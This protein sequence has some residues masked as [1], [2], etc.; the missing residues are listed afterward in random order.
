MN[1][2]FIQSHGNEFLDL[3]LEDAQ[4]SVSGQPASHPSSLAKPLS[5]SLAGLTLAACGGGGS[6]GP[7]NGPQ[8]QTPPSNLDSNG[9]V[10]DSS[11]SNPLSN[12]NNTQNTQD[13]QNSPHKT[14]PPQ[15][16]NEKE[17]AR[18]LMQASFGGTYAQVQDVQNKGFE[19]WLDAE[20]NRP[21]N[22]LNSHFNWYR[23]HGYMQANTLNLQT[24]GLDNSLWRKLMT[25][26]DLLRQKVAYALSQIFVVSI[27]GLGA[28]IWRGL[29]ALSFMDL[30]EKNAFANYKDLLREVSLSPAMGTYLN[31]AGSRKASGNSNPDE[32]YAREVMQL[33]SIGL[34]ELNDDGSLKKDVNDKPIETYTQE[35]VTQLAKIFTGWYYRSNSSPNYNDLKYVQERMKNDS[36]YFTPGDKSFF[37]KTV[38]A[39][40]SAQDALFQVLDYLSAHDNVGPFIGRQLIQRLVCSNPSPKFIYD[41]TQVFNNDGTGVRGNL[42]AVIRAILLHD[43]ARKPSTNTNNNA[44]KYY[45]KLKEPIYRVAQWGRTFEAKTKKP[46]DT[47]V[48]ISKDTNGKYTATSYWEIGDYSNDTSLAQAPMR[49]P[50]VFNFFRPG[51]VPTQ[52]EMSTAGITAPE[53]QLCNEVTVAAYL[54]LIKG[55]IDVGRYDVVPS[56]SD[57]D[58]ELTNK[59]SEFVDRYSMLLTGDSLS[60]N[61]K[62]W[63]VAAITDITG[64]RTTNSTPPVTYTQQQDRL[65][66]A[67]FLIMATPEYMIQK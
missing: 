48:V 30:L 65:R 25:A 24:T 51:Y 52:G 22:E 54:N 49:S 57:A 61:T 38:S 36:T 62:K 47:Q 44:D 3:T 12:D 17:A 1:S 29:V 63:I 14:A 59:P 40:T 31:M 13:T 10:I 64:T 7:S 33:F 35:N 4:S 15:P 50:S 39:G 26:P 37:D 5:T 21:W 28:T 67:I 23:D 11:N 34:Y 53:F 45:G 9:Y 42:K 27:N 19:A 60:L 8:N 56:Y 41:I 55:L 46:L 32:N 58:L 66:V 6:N 20:L 43:E 16:P 2:D 18:F